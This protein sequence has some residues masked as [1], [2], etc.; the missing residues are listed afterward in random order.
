MWMTAAEIT[1]C[2][3]LTNVGLDADAEG[4]EAVHDCAGIRYM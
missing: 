1:M 2:W 3:L 4:R